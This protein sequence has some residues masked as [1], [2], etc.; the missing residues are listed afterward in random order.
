MHART[1]RCG[2]S[3]KLGSIIER[4]PLS[5]AELSLGK[6]SA[7]VASLSSSCPAQCSCQRAGHLLPNC[8]LPLHDNTWHLVAPSGTWWHLVSTTWNKCPP[9]G[10]LEIFKIPAGALAP[11]TG[12]HHLPHIGLGPSGF[13]TLKSSRWGGVFPWRQTFGM[14]IRSV[15]WPPS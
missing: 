6:T 12:G 10:C 2:P 8:C 9:H 4:S 1:L 15:P 14:Q 11:H 3:V 13:E 5:A 7:V